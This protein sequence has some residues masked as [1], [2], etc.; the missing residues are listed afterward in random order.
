MSPFLDFEHDPIWNVLIRFAAALLVMFIIL[1]FIYSRFS[2]KKKNVFSFFLMGIMIF[3][4][5]V[6]L[7]TVEI[8]LGVTLGLF[9]I[10]A[11]LRFR[12]ENLPL[13]EMTYFFTVIGVAVINA[14]ASFY[15]PVRGTILINSIIILSVYLLELYYNNKSPLTKS[16]RGKDMKKNG[17]ERT[18]LI[19]DRLELLDPGHS[20][21]LLKDVSSRTGIKISGIEVRKIDLILKNAELELFFEEKGDIE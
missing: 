6:L 2:R 4:V 13:R 19:Y 8:Q 10:F 18:I 21:E 1:R 3:L 15:S 14:M 16:K 11:L 12:S 17:N 5:C 9:A 7:K 20:E